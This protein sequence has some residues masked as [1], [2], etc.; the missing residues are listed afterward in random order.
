MCTHVRPLYLHVDSVDAMNV[1]M[2]DVAFALVFWNTCGSRSYRLQIHDRVF[3]VAASYGPDDESPV[4][5]SAETCAGKFLDVSEAGHAEAAK[6]VVAERPQIFVDLMAHTT[7]AR[8]GVGVKAV[9]NT[10]EYIPSQRQY[11]SMQCR[12]VS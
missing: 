12:V 8:W 1:D 5:R 11:T 6:A 10:P 9:L 3:A 7:E 2:S 4:R